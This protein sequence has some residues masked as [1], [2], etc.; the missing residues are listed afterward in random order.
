M[1]E[2]QRI[3][4]TFLDGCVK[5]F[6][7][8]YS[9]LR[10][11]RVYIYGSGM[12]GTFLA[13]ALVDY[14]CVDNGSIQAFIN[15]FQNGFEVDGIPVVALDECEFAIG[16]SPDYCVVVGIEN[17]RAVIDR[18]KER[19]IVFFADSKAGLASMSIPL[20]NAFYA[21][22]TWMTIGNVLQRIE[23]FHELNLPEGEM[24]RFYEDNDSLDVLNNRIELYKTGKH[25]LLETCPI[26]QAEYFAEELLDI[27]TNEVYADVGAYTGDTVLAFAEYTKRKY[28]KILAFEPD[29]ETFRSLE[30]NTV[31]LHDVE[32]FEMAT[33]SK[34][35][36]VR[37]ADGFGVGSF[38]SEELG[39]KRVKVVRLDDIIKTPLSLV[40][41]DIEGAELDTLHG[42]ERLLMEY[43]PKL[44]VCV[45]HKVE[46]LYEIPKYLKEIVPEYR[47][48]LRQHEASIYETVLYAEV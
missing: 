37:F 22:Q 4:K 40:K 20:M 1:N 16:S 46:D 17:N 43:R 18:L 10:G 29:A 6:K 11:K 35:G 32:L 13:Q 48:K 8:T 21:K 19:N 23:R 25:E 27:G 45:Y 9:F 36:E 15:D 31:G 14:G 5:R 3:Q 38:V 30:R 7:E 24:F 33:G 12:Y 41:M 26:T 44:A 28:K 42:M 39:T 47:L 34:N 2:I